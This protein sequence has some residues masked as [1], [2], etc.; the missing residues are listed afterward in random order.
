MAMLKLG[1]KASAEQFAPAQLLDFGVLAEESCWGE[2]LLHGGGLMEEWP[3]L[4]AE[5]AAVKR[6]VGGERC[7]SLVICPSRG[8]HSR[9]SE[10]LLVHRRIVP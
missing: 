7:V 3:M 5:K 1:Y 6:R 10:Q 9:P 8:R 4:K 2:G